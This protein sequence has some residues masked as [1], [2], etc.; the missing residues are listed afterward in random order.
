MKD[1]K[2]GFKKIFIKKGVKK[3]Y[4]GNL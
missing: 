2:R 1:G 4:L 3:K